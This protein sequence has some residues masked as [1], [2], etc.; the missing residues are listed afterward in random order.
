[1][2]KCRFCGAELKKGSTFCMS[3]GERVDMQSQNPA[4][5]GG[6]G[7]AAFLSIILAILL[8]AAISL[9]GALLAARALASPATVEKIVYS[10]DLRTFKMGSIFG[11]GSDATL[12]KL[13]HEK[14]GPLITVT[15][16]I[17]EEELGDLLEESTF[18][19]FASQKL[20]SYIDAVKAGSDRGQVTS[21]EILAL[22]HENEKVMEETLGVNLFGLGEGAVKLVLDNISFD[23]L[24]LSK[25]LKPAI[26][27][28]VKLVLGPATLYA[29]IGVG[30]VLLLLLLVANRG[31]FHM[32]IIWA[33][34][35]S[36]IAVL[37]FY[38]ASIKNLLPKEFYG[39]H[40]DIAMPVMEELNTIF[41]TYFQILAIAAI[42]LFFVGGIAGIMR[43][44]KQ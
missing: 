15:L 27:A 3:C 11:N 25:L 44:K 38:L 24:S 12:P 1:M 40:T 21:D 41:N 22:M 28:N 31:R 35:S 29:T 26:M 4:K 18:K 13:L 14:L 17:K 42:A 8:A 16:G 9:G 7:G 36:A 6:G 2:E 37:V 5:K 10:L 33:S 19:K 32:A 30:V 43:K 34:V 39:K 23:A 20:S